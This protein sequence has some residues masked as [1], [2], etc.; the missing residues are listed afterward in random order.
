MLR[1]IVR[2]LKLLFKVVTDST[3]IVFEWFRVLLLVF[4]VY[5]KFQEIHLCGSKF[6]HKSL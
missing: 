4:Y 2:G 3:D 5:A 6:I 1:I